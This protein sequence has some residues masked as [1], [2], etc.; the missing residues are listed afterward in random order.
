[1]MEHLLNRPP[2][3]RTEG[4]GTLFPLLLLSFCI[5]LVV[6]SGLLFAA[7]GSA[8]QE[9]RDYLESYFS[10]AG[11]EM[12][13]QPAIWSV[14]WDVIRWPA[15]AFVLGCTVLGVFCIPVLLFLRG[16]L[17]SYAVSLFL[18]LFGL[19]GL[20]AAAA[21]FGV[22]ALMVLPGLMAICQEGFCSALE[23][24]AP[25]ERVVFSLRR[26]LTAVLPAA[27]LLAAAALLQWSVMPALLSAVCA[28]FFAP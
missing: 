20:A 23:R 25:G 18:R 26:K 8:S 15:A 6:L 1:M 21:V 2:A 13:F 19:H 28:R 12:S 17:L 14:I 7:L 22:P 5:G 16:F 24:L 27:G 10:M 4:D 9:L 11:A 3:S